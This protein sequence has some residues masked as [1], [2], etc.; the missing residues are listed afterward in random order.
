MKKI[1]TGLTKLRKLQFTILLFALMLFSGQGWGQI[2]ITANGT[3][4]TQNFDGIG[5]TA[6]ASLPS[7]WKVSSGIIYSTSTSTT[8]T[9]AYGSSGTGAVTGTS[10][11][12]TVNWAN[13]INASS[14][15]RAVGFLTTGSFSSPRSLFVQ[16]T[17][18]TGSTI[19]SLSITFDIEKYRSGSRAWD[20]NF[21]SSIDGT[22]WTSQTNGDQSYIADANNTVI[23]NPPTTISKS[24]TI[25][26]L[27]IANGSSYYLRWA[28][29]GSGGSTNAQG[30]GIDNF[31]ITTTG[32]A[33][34]PTVTSPNASNITDVTAVLGGTV[35][36]DGGAT[37]SET[38]TVWKT[39]TGVAISDNRLA[40]AGTSTGTF[41]HSRSALPSGTQIFY[42]AYATNSAG[43]G[44]STESSFYTLSTEPSAH[45]SSFLATAASQTQLNLTFSA[46]SIIPAS[47]YLILQKTGST[48]TGT[49]TD[50]IG[51]TLTSTIGDA[52]VAAI[53]TNTNDISTSIS[54]LTAGTH[55]YYKIYPFNWFGSNA[56]TLNYKT[57]GTIPGTD[58]S[59]SNSLDATS[60]VSG[61]AQGSQ[62]AAMSISSLITTD[63]AAIRVFDMNV[64]DYGNKDG[65]PTKITQLTIKAGNN[66]TADWT[67]TIQGIQLW[68]GTS[69]DFVTT[70][71]STI[72]ANTIVIPIVSGNLN[73]DNNSAT[74]ISLYIYLK[75]S[76]LVDNSVLEFKVDVTSHGFIADATG[77][78]F[79]PSFT[80][81][82][83]S[84]Q[85]TI[86]V[87][88]T[89][90]NFAIQP[91]NTT[92]NANFNAAVEA[93]DANN[94]RDLDV[95]STVTLNTSAGNLS[96]VISGL[97]PSMAA[98]YF[99]WTD[100]QNNTAGNGITL[101][102]TANSLTPATSNAFKILSA[103]PTTQASAI[104]FSNVALNSM[105]V[106]WTNGD[107]GNRI[108]VAKASATP[109]TNPTNGTT[110]S[111]NSVFGTLGT[112]IAT[113]EYVVYN[114]N[115][116]SVNVSNL[117]ASTSYTFKVFEYNGGSGTENYLTTSNAATQATTAL[118]YY[119]IGS[120]DPAQVANWKTNRDG[121][122]TSPANFTSGEV[123]VIESGD[124]MSTTTTW[125]ISGTN[126]KLQIENGGTLTANNAVTLAA[127]TTFQI[128]NGGTY[129]Q[130]V[131][132]TMASTIF[133]GTEIFG[134]TSNFEIKIM[135]S[136]TAA[137][138]SPGWGNLTL[139]QITGATALGWSGNLSS[140]QGNLTILGTGSGTTRHAITATPDVVANIG[141]DLIVTNGNFWL[142]SGAG[143]CI[144]NLTGNLLINGGTLNIS[145]SSG[146]G[147]INV[148]GNVSV[149]S[150]ILTEGGSTTS[151]TIVFNKT[152]AQT[153]TSGGT[154]SNTVNFLVASTS[155]TD[156]GTSVIS[157]GGAF[158]LQNGATLKT[159]NTLG[160]D[161][162]ITVSG[163]KTFDATANYTFNGSSAQVCGAL[164]P[165][166]VN[167]LTIDN[168][169]GVGLSNSALTVNGTLLINSGKILEIGVGK[170]LTVAGTGA[171]TNNAGNTGLIIKS[172]GSLI[173]SS[174]T[175]AATME[176]DI[177]AA[178]WSV[179]DDGWHLLSSPM[180]AQAISGLFTPDGLSNN[181]YD[182][183]AW[184]EA[185]YQWLNQKI[186]AHNISNFTPGFG[187]LAAYQAGGTKSFV[188]NLNNTD[189]TN[190]LSF[191]YTDPS[192]KGY[193]LLGNPYSS[194]IDWSAA[195]WVKTNIEGGTAKVYDAVAK[196]FV[197]VSLVAS[198][199]TNIIPANQGFFVKALSAAS[200]TIPA[201]SRV[202][203]GQAFY[204]S[205]SH[206][207]ILK[208][209]KT[210]TGFGDLMGI[211]FDAAATLGYDAQ[212]DASEIEAFADAPSLYSVLQN[213]SKLSINTIPEQLPANTVV[214][215]NFK[216]RSDGQYN[217]N[218]ISIPSNTNCSTL[219]LE[220]L[221]TNTFQN[222]NQYPIYS[223]TA[224]TTD[225]LN[226]FILHFS[227]SAMGIQAND[228]GGTQVY[229]RDGQLIVNS[230]DN[231]LAVE[232]FNEI[233][234]QLGVYKVNGNSFRT[235]ANS[236]VQLVR[237]LMK[238]RTIVRKVVSL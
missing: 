3:A 93:T 88:A 65:Q 118:T 97:T 121:T 144:V 100:L 138:S 62:P 235:K 145:N 95:A 13:G 82:P 154:I 141:G 54:S 59:T 116:N 21:F 165:A 110:Y 218:A 5:S 56:A 146:V 171:L 68:N 205:T 142:S 14:T 108:V 143:N 23:N 178:N 81:A 206:L 201:N 161:G 193:N 114:G 192:S 4:F 2:S 31:S 85:M 148:G 74:T 71:S 236:K 50:G 25:S 173:Q 184:D 45:A 119:S 198:P 29:T 197:D 177:T 150:G 129:I 55:Y 7:G 15:D 80:A 53:I 106:G 159:A 210:G 87:V 73:I 147:T 42:K 213:G 233:G 44:L 6:T 128:D 39:S 137:P 221:K 156:L 175:V 140:I 111:A 75:S 196:N 180:A 126:S 238:D 203:S 157:G 90:L 228:M 99:A 130:N 167:N 113:N 202:H 35:T 215:L 134:P 104:L 8:T 1:I 131:A 98:G 89:K 133:S 151:S 34:A 102:A 52:S 66:N 155:I 38:G 105:T 18:N 224:T 91:S 217:I 22:T 234:Q 107:G 214:H 115:G 112:A 70:A 220:D 135:P 72:T 219:M 92:V 32:G 237:I 181:G 179:A 189:V 123:F 64:K 48:P 204:K 222:L 41:T 169:A 124:V 208:A 170:Q 186:G 211:N 231:I 69:L 37:L 10:A 43:T 139:N 117:N 132:M 188:G 158:T 225:N 67:N 207:L 19:S 122:G 51:Y 30:L 223:Y 63:G 199:N 232:I 185:N 149:T 78:T 195:S 183:Y 125:S 40:I 212:Y 60:E 152:G 101:S 77:S 79:L 33:T 163:N 209:E 11:G 153:F 109:T 120:G 61:P 36:S 191:A 17:N 194:A 26:G 127:S 190:P 230:T 136:G 187:Y 84:N 9:V 27:S 86:E 200:F 46:A 58:A 96:S 166:S 168:A 229:S 24:V 94:N 28:Y 20:I 182:F 227:T 16:I 160:L 226:R 83:V 176:R 164:L 174:A 12:G 47:G 216:A 172:G 103:Q 162:S 57:D 76:G 49:P